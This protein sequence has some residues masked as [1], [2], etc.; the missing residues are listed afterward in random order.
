MTLPGAPAPLLSHA[1]IV[2]RVRERLHERTR[3]E[4]TIAGFR[5]A[6]VAIMLFAEHD[7]T[8]VTLTRRSPALRAHSGQI[9]LPGGV[10]DPGDASPAD[11]A[12]RESWEELG[13]APDQQLV[14]GALDDELTPT[15]FVITPVITTLASRPA[16]AP[17]PS[18]VDVVIEVPLLVFSN[19]GRVEDLGQRTIHGIVCAMR[20]VEYDGH[21]IT[22]ATARILDRLATLI[23]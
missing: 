10:R 4:L 22:G 2:E 21:R 17:N 18:E 8:W 15:G 6:A 9:S 19:P 1:Q 5:A 13:V 3:R 20:A 12:L 23:G 11:T 14:L 7:Q 16:Y